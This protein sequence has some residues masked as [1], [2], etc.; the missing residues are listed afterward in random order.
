MAMD[1]ST[2]IYH[3]RN[4]FS[5]HNRMAQPL[6]L[7]MEGTNPLTMSKWLWIAALIS[8][9]EGTNTLIMKKWLSP[10]I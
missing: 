2:H 7:T 3:G 9:M 10:Y 1:F 4:Q 8:D 6:Y 5:H